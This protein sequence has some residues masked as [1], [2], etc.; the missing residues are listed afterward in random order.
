MGFAAVSWTVCEAKSPSRLAEMLAKARMT[1]PVREAGCR[2]S[3]NRSCRETSASQ[4]ARPRIEIVVR[5]S[6]REPEAKRSVTA[7]TI[8][9]SNVMTNLAECRTFHRKRLL[10]DRLASLQSHSSQHGILAELGDSRA[11]KCLSIS[12]LGS[13]RDRIEKWL[14]RIK[15][16]PAIA[17]LLNTCPVRA[18]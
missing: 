15:P 16:E 5:C 17:A 12:T 1:D 11:H 6:Y 4:S 10:G 14:A 2:H 18:H 9:H 7:C 8:L 13:I 3:E